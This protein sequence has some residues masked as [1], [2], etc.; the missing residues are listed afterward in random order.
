[1][2]IV[3]RIYLLMLVLGLFI[4]VLFVFV[5]VMKEMLAM[6]LMCFFGWDILVVCIYE[7]IFEGMWL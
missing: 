7:M 1:M 3:C 5:D 4:V 2:D 6:L